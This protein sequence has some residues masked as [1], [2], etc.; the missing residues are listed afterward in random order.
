M[1]KLIAVMVGLMMVAA[2]GLASDFLGFPTTSM[3]VSGRNVYIVW[4]PY[5]PNSHLWFLRSVDGGATWKP[6]QDLGGPCGITPAAIAASGANVYVAY[7]GWSPRS[8]HLLRSR[9]GGA[10][11][12]HQ[13]NWPIFYLGNVTVVA[14]GEHVDLFWMVQDDMI[15]YSSSKDSGGTWTLPDSLPLEGNFLGR[16]Y[17]SPS[18]EGDTMAVAW[19][20]GPRGVGFFRHTP[21]DTLLF[22]EPR[23]PL[24]AKYDVTCDTGE[25]LSG[26][27]WSQVDGQGR[28][29]VFAAKLRDTGDGWS[30]QV[31]L[32]RDDSDN[33][34]PSLRHS[35]KILYAIW[36]SMVEGKIDV[37]VARSL[38]AG[39]S[40]LPDRKISLAASPVWVFPKLATAGSNVHACWWTW[41]QGTNPERHD[42]LFRRSTDFGATWKSIKKIASIT[43]E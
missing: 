13:V 17:L 35:G 37:R 31:K 36:E 39:S 27:A 2:V 40:W 43:L 6:I 26:L 30:P 1:K 12:E 9:D 11:W 24:I 20:E 23:P 38:N 16:G 41:V 3:A 19:W 29:A 15:F 32:S 42:L 4:S 21:S 25:S 33:L 7:S 28:Y 34:H 8:I 5:L 14:S 18:R 22:V 10:T